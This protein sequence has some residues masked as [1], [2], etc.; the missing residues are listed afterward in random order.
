M[1]KLEQLIQELCPNGV[2]YKKLGEV[3]IILDNLRK[4]V[5]KEKR[6]KGKY[7]YYGANGIQDYV[8]DYIF[9]GTFLLMGEDGS[10]INTDNSPV[11]NWVSGKVWVNNHAHVLSCDNLITLRFIFYALQK[12]DVSSVVRGVPPKLNQDNLRKIIIPVPPLEIQK[13]IVRILD[14]FTELEKT[15]EKELEARK[16]QFEYYRE[17]LLTFNNSSSVNYPVERERDE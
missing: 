3:C 12:V 11:L 7:P 1:N 2:E 14:T 15:L 10:V 13:E 17:K 9:D 16:K 5:S 6:K 4:P 8:E